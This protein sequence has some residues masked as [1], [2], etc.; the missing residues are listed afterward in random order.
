MDKSKIFEFVARYEQ[1]F[2]DS[3]ALYGCVKKLPPHITL[4]PHTTRIF[5]KDEVAALYGVAQQ[6][7]YAY[8]SLN[9]QCKQIET[10]I[11]NVDSGVLAGEI[12][13]V[14]PKDSSL[15]I[16][17]LSNKVLMQHYAN[18][19]AFYRVL[20]ILIDA[21]SIYAVRDGIDLTW[22]GVWY[23]GNTAETMKQLN[24]LKQADL[25]HATTRAQVDIEY[26]RQA[27]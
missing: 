13:R 7:Y 10:G 25:I 26:P 11:I 15:K 19:D 12:M 14:L 16:N 2:F 8:D 22:A 23:H 5:N 9:E 4:E 24:M 17:E 20:R 21:L 27:E 3:L 18:R 1:A 6:V